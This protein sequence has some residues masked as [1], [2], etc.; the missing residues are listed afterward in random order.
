LSLRIELQAPSIA[1]LVQR[2]TSALRNV[3]RSCALRR[4]RLTD[5]PDSLCRSNAHKR[6]RS[7][8]R[9]LPDAT[10][11]PHTDRDI[12]IA[13]ALL[14]LDDNIRIAKCTH[15]QTG[16]YPGFVVVIESDGPTTP[17][18][19]AHRKILAEVAVVLGPELVLG[20]IAIVVAVERVACIVGWVVL[21]EC[22]DNVKLYAR[23]ACEAIKSKVRVSL[24]VVVGSIV[25]HAEIYLAAGT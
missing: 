7:R 18:R 6:P 5:R 17:V 4:P 16:S 21:G 12:R 20:A 24:R 22:L 3:R 2:H 19:P 14:A 25:D 1:H 8:R 10:C 23:I 13:S 11:G 9:S 15:G